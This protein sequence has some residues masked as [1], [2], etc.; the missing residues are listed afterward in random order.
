M[1]AIGTEDNFHFLVFPQGKDLVRLYAGYRL[2][3][4]AR[5]AGPDREARLLK[6]FQLNCLPYAEAIL[7]G[8]PIGSFNSYSNE[9]HWVDHPVAPGVVLIGDAAGH[10]DPV[11]GQGVSI[12]ARDVRIVSDILISTKDLGHPDFS[13][14]VEECA[15]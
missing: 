13:S 8:N 12:T 4:R 14:Y 15:A 3:D 11:T 5:F 2:S 9:D 7:A 1:Q 10:N 6:A